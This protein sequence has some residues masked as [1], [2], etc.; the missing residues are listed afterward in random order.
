MASF[1]FPG[2]AAPLQYF[3]LTTTASK[4]E[5]CDCDEREMMRAQ[6]EKKMNTENERTIVAVH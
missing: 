1:F 6:N 5:Q 4:R 3:V 2:N